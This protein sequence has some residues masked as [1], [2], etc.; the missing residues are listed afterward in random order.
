LLSTSSR[1]IPQVVDEMAFQTRRNLAQRALVDVIPFSA[2]D[3]AVIKQAAAALARGTI[4]A[5][6]PPRFL[7]SACRYAIEKGVSLPALSRRVIRH[8]ATIAGRQAAGP[9]AAPLRAAA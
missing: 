4:P 3:E 5:N 7:V 2:R 9:G 1:T 8:L 6:V